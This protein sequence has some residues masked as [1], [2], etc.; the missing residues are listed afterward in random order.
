MLRPFHDVIFK[1]LFGYENGKAALIHLCESFL[2]ESFGE[3]VLQDTQVT[4]YSHSDKRCR[5]DVFFTSMANDK[6]KKVDIEAQMSSQN[7]FWERMVYYWSRS[8]GH[9]FK[10]GDDYATLKETVL[11]I[12]YNELFVESGD[13]ILDF[14]IMDQRYPEYSPTELLRIVCVELPKFKKNFPFDYS[15]PRH[16][17]LKFLLYYCS[18]NKDEFEEVFAM[19]KIIRETA[20]RFDTLTDKQKEYYQFLI[21]ARTSDIVSMANSEARK[22]R[23]EGIAE[24][25]VEGKEEGKEEGLVVGNIEGQKKATVTLVKKV[26]ENT[27]SIQATAILIGMSEDEVKELIK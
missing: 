13:G 14:K 15:D 24:G 11:L 21:D 2:G 19:H 25:R 23:E 27:G 26:Y 22:A 18:E 20:A 3:I 12:F 16:C 7:Y 4:M 6:R 5:L 8:F 17:W 9:D 10:T 1:Y